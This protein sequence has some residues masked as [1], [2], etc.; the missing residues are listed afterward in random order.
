M[1]Q[2]SGL[3]LAAAHTRAQDDGAPEPAQTN[4]AGLAHPLEAAEQVEERLAKAPVHEAV[5]DWIATTGR[6]GEQLEEADARIGDGLVQH[7]GH[8]EHGHRV[9]DVERGPAHEKLDNDH[10]QHLNHALLV[11][12]ALLH[13]GPE[14]DGWRDGWQE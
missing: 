14:G 3:P 2:L 10:G 7:V 6:V 4:P 12:Q 1:L 5:R 13:V 9:D 11:Q 8:P